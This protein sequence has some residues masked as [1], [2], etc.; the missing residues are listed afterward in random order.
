MKIETC[1]RCEFCNTAYESEEAAAICEASH[2]ATVSVA[3]MEYA[4]GA[5]Y[6]NF[7]QVGFA[8]G[9]YCRYVFNRKLTPSEIIE[10]SSEA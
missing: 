5:P 1:Y 2:H 9:S 10:E 8:N 6:P 4:S 3:P 7:V